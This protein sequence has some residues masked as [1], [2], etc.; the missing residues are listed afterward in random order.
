MKRSPAPVGGEEAP[1]VEI[2]VLFV[3]DCP[4]LPVLLERLEAVTCGRAT[5]TTTQVG[6]TA[7]IP[8][9]FAGSPTLLVNGRNPFGGDGES[10]P[11]CALRI[12]SIE[13]LKELLDAAQR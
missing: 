10:S 6:G 1:R 11:S 8:P 12:P 3:D 7:P 9:G 5:V 13:Q 4:N 2:E